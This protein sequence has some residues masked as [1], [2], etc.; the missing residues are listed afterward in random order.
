[1]IPHTDSHNKPGTRTQALSS[2]T[3]G[4]PGYTV[5]TICLIIDNQADS[6]RISATLPYPDILLEYILSFGIPDSGPLPGLA[7]TLRPFPGSN[8]KGIS[9]C[10][11]IMYQTI[12]DLLI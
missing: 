11:L 2:E 4:I 6:R 10:Q 12:I 7:G 5:K 1:M 8:L 9:R 3:S